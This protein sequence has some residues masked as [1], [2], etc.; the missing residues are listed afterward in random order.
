MSQHEEAPARPL[1]DEVER[2]RLRNGWT[3]VQL[4]KRAG[5]GRNTID[6][7]RTQPRAPL[8]PTVKDVAERLDIDPEM[9]LRLAGIVSMNKPTP[10]ERLADHMA[11][12]LDELGLNWD[13][14]IRGTLDIR[15][16][17][18]ET[19]STTQKAT[20]ERR[21]QWEPGS[22]EAILDGDDP[23]PRGAELADSARADDTLTVTKRD[24]ELQ[25]LFDEAQDDPVL[26]EALLSVARL[27]ETRRRPPDKDNG[28]QRRQSG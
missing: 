28:E 11:A 14:T 18:V 7:W 19:L 4:A 20:I 17:R 8:A 5:V 10:R 13:E 6:N 23:T 9:A 24:E 1:Y 15:K 3:K 12:R 16:Y 27:R 21:L 2:I 22:V 25:E 26:R